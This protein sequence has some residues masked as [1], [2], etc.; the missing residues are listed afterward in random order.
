MKQLRAFVS[1]IELCAFLDGELAADRRAEIEALLVRAPEARA[2]LEVWRRQGH[3]M[4]ASFGRIAQEP[5][6]R[7]LLAALTQ[8]TEP[9]KITQPLQV[10]PAPSRE[11]ALQ[12]APPPERPS[13]W[14]RLGFAVLGLSAATGIL[15]SGALQKFGAAAE[16]QA[17]PSPSAAPGWGLSR[18]AAEAHAAISPHAE[19]LIDI[20]GAD[21]AVLTAAAVQSGL[22]A[23][24]PGGLAGLNLLGLR[25]TPA[26]GGLAGLLLYQSPKHGP[27]SLFVMREGRTDASGLV[28]RQLGELT[29]ASFHIDETAY[30]LTAAAPRDQIVAWASAL[31][32]TLAQPRSLRG[33]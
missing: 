31:R 11:T 16:P 24:L 3:I 25:L 14:R 1:D 10:V 13:I 6:P 4:Q 2:K 21:A 18:H 12:I 33:S 26:D 22:N 28:L 15:V 8:Q 20:R 9:G 5:L 29:I 23:R 17:I 19:R 30:V 32:S 27:A 7:P